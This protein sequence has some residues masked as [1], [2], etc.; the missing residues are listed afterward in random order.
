MPAAVAPVF[1]IKSRF[2]RLQKTTAGWVGSKAGKRNDF[3]KVDAS[4]Y[5]DQAAAAGAVVATVRVGVLQND[6]A[7]TVAAASPEAKAV[8]YRQC[9]DDDEIEMA[10]ITSGTSFTTLVAP[11]AA[12]EGDLIGIARRATTGEYVW[13]TTGNDYARVKSVNIARGTL[14][15]VLLPTMRLP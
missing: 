6:V 4:G 12:M 9:T 11:T 13:D 8:G 2:S 1:D 3:C 14:T 15:G 10:V 5:I 7:S